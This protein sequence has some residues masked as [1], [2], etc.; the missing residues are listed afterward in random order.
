MFG[1]W[2]ITQ[3]KQ[4]MGRSHFGTKKTLMIIQ[5][6]SNTVVSTLQ[7]K[8]NTFHGYKTVAHEFIFFAND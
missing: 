6:V 5:Q 4:V 7:T 8:L 1:F 3:I 2:A